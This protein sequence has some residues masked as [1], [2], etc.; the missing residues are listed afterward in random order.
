[1]KDDSTDTVPTRIS[2]MPGVDK[3]LREV[4]DVIAEAFAS[5]TCEL[6]GT[7]AVFNGLQVNDLTESRNYDP[8]LLYSVNS[9]GEVK[10]L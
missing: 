3:Y 9:N 1:M 6:N 8:Q 5:S 10:E 4:C 7:L 2:E